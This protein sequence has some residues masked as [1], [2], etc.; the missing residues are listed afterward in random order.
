MRNTLEVSQC[1]PFPVACSHAVK[2]GPIN[3][4][5]ETALSGEQKTEI[6]EWLPVMSST[7]TWY[8]RGAYFRCLWYCHGVVFYASHT[9]ENEFEEVSPSRLLLTPPTFGHLGSTYAVKPNAV[10]CLLLLLV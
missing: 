5:L 1:G 10:H 6:E 3:P 7:S 9:I 4:T 2:T 8:C